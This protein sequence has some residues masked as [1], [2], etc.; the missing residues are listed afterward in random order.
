MPTLQ[1]QII[2]GTLYALVLP[3][4]GYTIFT[5]FT[6]WPIF[7]LLFGPFYL[8]KLIL[9]AGFVPTLLTAL[10]FEFF[11]K[12]RA[13]PQSMALTAIVGNLCAFSWYL[14][15]GADVLRLSYVS[16]ALVIATT[17]SV[18]LIPLM[19]REL[20]SK[21]NRMDCDET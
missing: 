15:L 10:A 8:T 1:G 17:A 12:N 7:G 2:R 6:F 13:L 16:L 21:M 4:V 14:A 5:L 19:D 18:V 9:T 3:L 20:R 11:L